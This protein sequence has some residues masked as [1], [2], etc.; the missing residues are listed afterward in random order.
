M[1]IAF[2]GAG[3]VGGFYGAQM[4]RQGHDVS[5]IARG[6]HLEAIQKN[7]L[8]V[9]GPLGDYTVKPRAESDP[10]QIGPVE[11]VVHTV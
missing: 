9:F 10:S 11:Y 5:F 3:A 2:I 4:A 7:G 1:R 8:R 6:A